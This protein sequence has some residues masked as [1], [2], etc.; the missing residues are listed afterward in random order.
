MIDVL[1]L[2]DAIT[3]AADSISGGLNSISIAIVVFGVVLLIIN[4]NNGN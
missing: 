2:Q 4:S 1:Q 3:G